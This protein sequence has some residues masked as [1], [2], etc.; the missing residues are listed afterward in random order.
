MDTLRLTRGGTGGRFFFVG[1]GAVL[2]EG[3]FFCMASNLARRLF[4][5]SDTVELF[6]EGDG[7]FVLVVDT[8]EMSV[9]L[10]DLVKVVVGMISL[11][12]EV[13]GGDFLELN[14]VVRVG[15]GS[16]VVVVVSIVGFDVSS[17]LSGSVSLFSIRTV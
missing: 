10:V 8:L 7:G 17:G 12:C 2:V 13:D 1:G 11:I 5:A 16:L 3:I 4:V 15:V 6:N 14:L 9:T